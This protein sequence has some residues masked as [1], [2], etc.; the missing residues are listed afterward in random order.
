MSHLQPLCGPL[1]WCYSHPSSNHSS[2]FNSHLPSPTFPTMRTKGGGRYPEGATLTPTHRP[3]SP[4]LWSWACWCHSQR[5]GGRPETNGV[6]P[7]WNPATM[8]S[9]FWVPWRSSP[10]CV[11]P[12]PRVRE[13]ATA[14]GKGRS[15][16]K[17]HRS[18]TGVSRWDPPLSHPVALLGCHPHDELALQIGHC[19]AT[20][21]SHPRA[22]LKS[23]YSEPHEKGSQKESPK[24]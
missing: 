21:E 11:P 10:P 4:R 20:Q 7:P 15:R 1:P 6:H 24:G 19:G 18:A 16:R 12:S 13:E 5:K 9:S 23:T 14:S 2:C 8:L 17:G 22:T 3:Y